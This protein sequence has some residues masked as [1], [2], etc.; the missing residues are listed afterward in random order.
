MNTNKTIWE[1]RVIKIPFSDVPEY[2]KYLKLIWISTKKEERVLIKFFPKEYK[3][4]RIPISTYI[5]KDGM[6]MEKSVLDITDRLRHQKKG[7]TTSD[8]RYVEGNFVV[9]LRDHKIDSHF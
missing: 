3:H 7:L 2:A 8:A 5:Y 6:A 4:K 1:G 9:K